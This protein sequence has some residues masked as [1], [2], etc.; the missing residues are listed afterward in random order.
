LCEE[1]L[2]RSALVKLLRDEKWYSMIEAEHKGALES[3]TS[4]AQGRV[5]SLQGNPPPPLEVCDLLVKFLMRNIDSAFRIVEK[6]IDHAF[7]EYRIKL[8]N[9][10]GSGSLHEMARV[11][12]HTLVPLSYRP[13]SSYELSKLDEFGL[14]RA[15]FIWEL[16]SLFATPRRKVEATVALTYIVNVWST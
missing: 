13:L 7:I 4:Y 11:L 10:P 9:N 5:G 12:N 15:L 16:V 14:G 1:D 2:K 8:A 3:Y 6:M